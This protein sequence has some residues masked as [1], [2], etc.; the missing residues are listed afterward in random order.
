MSPI[1]GYLDGA[2]IGVIVAYFVVVFAV[3]IW[4][5]LPIIYPLIHATIRLVLTE[6]S[7]LRRWLLFG[8]PFYD[9]DSSWCL[10]VCQ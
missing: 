9:M 1:I 5:C 7:W 4:V 10:F 8:W 6:K 3:G 2:D